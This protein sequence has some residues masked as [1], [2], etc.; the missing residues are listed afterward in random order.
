MFSRRRLLHG[1]G[2]LGAGLV[3]AHKKFLASRLA[4]VAFFTALLQLAASRCSLYS[5][6][7]MKL[8]TGSMAT[9]QGL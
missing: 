5:S 1:A 3:A 9:R 8:D 7:T 2:A 6:T 4:D